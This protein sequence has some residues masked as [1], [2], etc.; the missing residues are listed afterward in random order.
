MKSIVTGT[1]TKAYALFFAAMF[2]TSCGKEDARAGDE[3]TYAVFL[4]SSD[5][6]DAASTSIS[7]TY[8]ITCN[9]VFGGSTNFT[10]NSVVVTG[11]S[12]SIQIL[13][14]LTC[15]LTLASFFDGTYTY[16]PSSSS[17]V[18]TITASGSVS[19]SGSL[20]SP[21]QYNNGSGSNLYL[22]LTNSTSTS[23]TFEYTYDPSQ[24]SDTVVN[25]CQ[26][27]YCSSKPSFSSESQSFNSTAISAGNDL[28]FAML[29]AITGIN[30]SITTNIWITD[31]TVTFTSGTTYTVSVPDSVVTLNPNLN[32]GTT[33]FSQ[34]MWQT[35]FPTT[36]PANTF[37]FGQVAAMPVATNL[38]GSIAGVTWQAHFYSDQPNVS[39]DWKWGAAVYTT[40]LTNYSGLSIKSGG[41]SDCTYNNTDDPGTPENDKSDLIAGGTGTGGSQY[42]GRHTS[43]TTITA[44]NCIPV[45]SGTDVRCPLVCQAPPITLTA[46]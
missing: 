20:T 34:N 40:N 5:F 23:L 22:F 33:T 27:S 38:P 13:A 8:N 9:S 28:W 11:T 18:I 31:A 6:V 12:G 46:R 1:A 36:W 44:D 25:P 42:T 39:V 35:T 3:K 17:L 37:I 43:G 16:T 21:P 19:S 15:T 24:Q 26:S 10:Q 4:R 32:C 45:C 41:N 29:I 14:N 30:T 7:T 2:F